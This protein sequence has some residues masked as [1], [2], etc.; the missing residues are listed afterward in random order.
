MET[1]DRLTAPRRAGEGTLTLRALSVV[2]VGAPLVVLPGHVDFARLPQQVFVQVSA[3]ALGLLFTARSSRLGPL[4]ARPLDLPLLAFLGWSAVSLFWTLDGEAGRGTLA[5]WSACAIVYLLVSRAGGRVDR[6]RLLAGLLL[7]GAIAAAAGLGQSLGG[8]AFIPQA[9]APASTLANRNVAAGYVAA[10]APLALLAWGSRAARIAAFAAAGTIL[11]YLPFTRSRSAA[12]AVAVQVVLVALALPGASW[13]SPL[14]R[15]GSRAGL[16]IASLG[17]LALVAWV[18]RTDIQKARSAAIRGSLAASAFSMVLERPLLGMGLGGYEAAYLAHGPALV[19]ATGA[20]FRVESPHNEGLQVLAETG[21]PGLLAGLWLVVA[22]GLA[23]RRL[24]RAPDPFVRRAAL[25]VGLSLCGFAVD[26]AFGFP[27]R[28]PVAPLALAVLLGVLSSLDTRRT[29]A[30]FHLALGTRPVRLAAA[31]ALGTL[32]VLAGSTSLSRLAQDRARYDAAFLPVALAQ[33]SPDTACG[34]R[35]SVERHS[36]GRLDLSARGAPLSDILRCLVERAGLQVDYD[37]PA[38]RQPVS[39]TLQ[40]ESL[41]EVLE[42]LLEGLGVNYLLGRDPTGTAVERLIVFGTSRAEPSRGGTSS[43]AKAVTSPE[44]P[45]ESSPEEEAPPF[46]APPA[47][48]P[49]VTPGFPSAPPLAEPSLPEGPEGEPPGIPEPEAPPY[50][51]ELTPL[52]LHLGRRP[53][54]SVARAGISPVR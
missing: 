19:S 54:P 10:I 28:Y 9:V 23:V 16:L 41:A 21:L 22:A 32:L 8:L 33:S 14:R 52:T 26:G 34:P 2:L 27:L 43:P 6:S 11:A 15:R 46:G 31:S 50:P 29:Q 49:G 39:V 44:P 7:G 36:D 45:D 5:H 51:E 38:P 17:L 37:G 42:Q 24:G 47:S 40:G 53:G 4:S 1:S 3:L 30:S 18:S 13:R 48:S 12:V 25:A 20:P 35:V